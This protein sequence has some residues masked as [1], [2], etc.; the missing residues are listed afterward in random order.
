MCKII[1]NV[2]LHEEVCILFRE[3]LL[4]VGGLA[5]ALLGW[6]RERDKIAYS[7]PTSGFQN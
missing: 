2:F 1:Y 6:V 4:F 7:L 3:R 5:R